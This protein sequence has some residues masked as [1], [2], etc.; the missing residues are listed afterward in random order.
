MPLPTDHYFVRLQKPSTSSTA[1]S[2]LTTVQQEFSTWLQGIERVLLALTPP[3]HRQYDQQ[4]LTLLWSAKEELLP[5]LQ[6][7]HPLTKT[8]KTT[9]AIAQGPA[10]YDADRQWCCSQV[11]KLLPALLQVGI[12]YSYPFVLGEQASQALPK[13]QL[14]YL[15]RSYFPGATTALEVYAWEGV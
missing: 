1:P 9:I 12:H 10:I 8:Q 3:L 15:T 11:P 5:L 6:A 13:D 4:G 2:D 7:L 14:N